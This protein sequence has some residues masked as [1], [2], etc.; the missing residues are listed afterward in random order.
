M[1]RKPASE[2]LPEKQWLDTDPEYQII[3]A[4]CEG[5]RKKGLTQKDL[6][7]ITGITQ[8]DISRLENGI[9]N[10]SL[11]TLERLAAGIGLRLKIEFVPIKKV[12]APEKDEE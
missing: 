2:R 5:R 9:A 8:G 1:G 4:I 11:K 6:A 12:R 7:D 10:P 3:K